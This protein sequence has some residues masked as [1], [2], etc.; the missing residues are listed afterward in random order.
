MMIVLLSLGLNQTESVKLN[1]QLW[2]Y[3]TMKKQTEYYT[4]LEK[5]VLLKCRWNEKLVWVLFNQEQKKNKL[6]AT[7]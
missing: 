4:H 7:F 1:R 2:R 5:N 6:S 3:T